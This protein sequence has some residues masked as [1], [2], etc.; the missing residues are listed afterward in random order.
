MGAPRQ[1]ASRP[2][3]TE[4]LPGVQETQ[5]GMSEW[6][7]SMYWFGYTGSPWIGGTDKQLSRYEG[8]PGGMGS[9]AVPSV[10][11]DSPKLLVLTRV[12]DQKLV[13]TGL[14]L[15]ASVSC[16]PI[17]QHSSLVVPG[18]LDRSIKHR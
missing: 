9:T 8:L 18:N 10:S 12:S 1:S 17:Q 16:T 14:A 6:E 11:D 15:K 13:V 5:L 7:N 4:R 3:G 2:G